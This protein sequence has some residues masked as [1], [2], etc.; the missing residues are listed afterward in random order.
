MLLRRGGMNRRV[1]LLL[2]YLPDQRANGSKQ[3]YA[4]RCPYTGADGHDL[5]VVRLL[6][7]IV[8][9]VRWQGG[10]CRNRYSAAGRRRRCDA[11]AGNG[12]VLLDAS[13]KSVGVV[14]AA[15]VASAAE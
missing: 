5:G 2:A 14:A 9:V 4:E 15:I 13:H 6:G 11:G 12:S 10:G 8:V 1:L 7:A 3:S